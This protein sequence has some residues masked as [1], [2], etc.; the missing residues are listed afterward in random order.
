MTFEGIDRSIQS[1]QPVMLY[2]ITTNTG[3]AYHYTGSDIAVTLLGATWTPTAIAHSA[4]TVNL[5]T[6]AREVVVTLPASSTFITQNVIGQLALPSK[7]HVIVYRAQLAAVGD[8]TRIEWE[9]DI[10]SVA[11][12]RRT[13]NLRVPS[14]RD[15]VLAAPIPNVFYQTKCN[16]TLYDTGC[17]VDRTLFDQ[18]ATVS[19]GSGVTFGVSTV[20]GHV[21]DYFRSGEIVRDLDGERRTIIRQ[22]GTSITI[23]TPFPTLAVGNAVTL[24]AGCDLY[25]ATCEAK[26]N[27]QAN[28]RGHPQ[29]PGQFY[30][31]TT[32]LNRKR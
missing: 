26:F 14:L 6:T 31:L 18:A 15:G 28:F 27:N 22:L 12:S 23:F 16:N 25:L 9:G 5:T 13:A 17:R 1:S 29:I 24:Y 4:P 21:D 20:G 32:L 2:Q 11:I 3:N 30:E 19:S 10:D 8:E 7:M